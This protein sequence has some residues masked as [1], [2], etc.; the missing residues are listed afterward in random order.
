MAMPARPVLM[1]CR[2]FAEDRIARDARM[3]SAPTV[4]RI[5]LARRYWKKSGI[6]NA[7]ALRVLR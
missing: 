3:L 4:T 1:A 2:A 7:P 5:M 6:G